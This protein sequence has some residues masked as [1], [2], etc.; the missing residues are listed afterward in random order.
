MA[1]K[2]RKFATRGLIHRLASGR[3]YEL[4]RFR[5][6]TTRAQPVRPVTHLILCDIC[7]I[8]SQDPRRTG[9]WGVVQMKP[10][11]DEGRH[12]RDS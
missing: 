8:L 9:A 6:E 12:R 4:D 11:V 2:N 3:C 7:W 5:A 10:K 1:F